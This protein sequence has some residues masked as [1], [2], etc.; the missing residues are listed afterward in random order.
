[1][2]SDSS[3][4]R[5]L[6]TNRSL[7]KTL[8]TPLQRVVRIHCIFDTNLKIQIYRGENSSDLAFGSLSLN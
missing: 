4:K 5:K 3:I 7:F 1:M 6:I 2:F 8:L